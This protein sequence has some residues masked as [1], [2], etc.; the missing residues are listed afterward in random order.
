MYREEATLLARR[1][2]QHRHGGA[3]RVVTAGLE[4]TQ[5]GGGSG[6]HHFASH[7][8][9]FLWDPTS[10]CDWHCGHVAQG[11]IPYLTQLSR[12]KFLF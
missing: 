1:D 7:P 4:W 9:P 5:G 3:H 10:C 2:E 12:K 8:P 11:I 6:G